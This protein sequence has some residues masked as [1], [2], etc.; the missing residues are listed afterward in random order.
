MSEPFATIIN[1]TP[2]QVRSIS[3]STINQEYRLFV[4]LPATYAQSNKRYPVLY[5]LDGNALYTLTRQIVEMLQ[6][7]NPLPELII[8]GIGYPKATHM[9]TVSLR[10]RDLTFIELTPEQ[11]A[12][13]D[14]PFQETGG[15]TQFLDFIEKEL[16]PFINSQYPTDRNDQALAGHSLGGGFV[17]YSM[18]QRPGLFRRNISISPGI[19]ETDLETARPKIS[20][21]SSLLGRLFIAQEI[22]DDDPDMQSLAKHAAA[23]VDLLR[24][25][26]F[27]DFEGVFQAFEGEDHA[28]VGI[29]GLTRGLRIVYGNA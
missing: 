1:P 14:Y 6:I 24:Q 15:G 18:L 2:T 27:E 8:V 22:P 25:K 11:K 29:V 9:E 5:V 28:S 23:F 26:H 4:S 3:S 20:N 12:E 16:L 7:V 13:T 17:L 19:D 10:G 21:I